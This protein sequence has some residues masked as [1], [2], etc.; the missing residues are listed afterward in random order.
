MGDHFATIDTGRNV[1][2]AVRLSVGELGPHLT[3]SPGLRPTSVLSGILILLIFQK[4]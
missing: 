2:A 1:G 3:V 4:E